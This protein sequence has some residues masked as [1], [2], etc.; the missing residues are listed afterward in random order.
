MGARQA[1]CLDGEVTD[2]SCWALGGDLLSYTQELGV[3]NGASE[4]GYRALREG[5]APGGRGE[6][7]PN[8][9]LN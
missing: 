2:P 7:S 8:S 6:V 3:W 9:H 1:R 4:L 5:E